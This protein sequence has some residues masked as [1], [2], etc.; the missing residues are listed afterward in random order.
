MRKIRFAG[1][2]DRV[3]KNGV[4]VSARGEVGEFGTKCKGERY[5]IDII[6]LDST[7]AF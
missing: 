3:T 4:K 6:F 5:A 2:W 7:E 1:F